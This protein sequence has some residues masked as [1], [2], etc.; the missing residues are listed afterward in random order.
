MTGWLPKCADDG[1]RCKCIFRIRSKLF[2]GLPSVTLLGTE[3]D[4]WENILLRVEK[5][6]GYGEEPAVWCDLLT[7]IL[8]RFVLGMKDLGAKEVLDFWLDEDRK[9]MYSDPGPRAE[10][11]RSGLSPS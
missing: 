3:E 5:L 10:Y 9:L 2:C 6:K 7:P 11:M 4:D 1:K 8:K